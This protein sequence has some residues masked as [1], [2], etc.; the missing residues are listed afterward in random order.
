MPHHTDQ[1]LE[2]TVASWLEA[3]QCPFRPVEDEHVA[4]RYEVRYPLWRNDHIMHVAG[5][6]G[7]VPSLAIASIT[8]MSPRHLQRF[9]ALADEEK[10]VFLFGL[11]HTLNTPEVD[12]ELKGATGL[13]CP[14]AF[15]VSVRRFADGLSLDSFARS[16][17]AVYKAELSAIWFIQ[18]SLD[19]D[20]ATPP[21]FFD[22]RGSDL[23]EA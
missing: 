7:P 10:R 17:G 6:P 9:S 8:R 11:R 2:R 12:F 15:Q 19:Q 22:L 1:D 18:E 23:P 21:V 16:I 13:E 20:P 4:W 3:L 14:E 5:V